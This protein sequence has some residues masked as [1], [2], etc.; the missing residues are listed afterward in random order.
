MWK[1]EEHGTASVNK[2]RFAEAK[3]TGAGT[4]A[5]GCPFCMVMLTGAAKA[6]GEQVKVLDMA[7][8][9]AARLKWICV[10]ASLLARQEVLPIGLHD[11]LIAADLHRNRPDDIPTDLG[12]YTNSP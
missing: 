9:L 2:T 12:C 11:I 4:L 10:F 8:I 6:D 7:K 1:E 3:A 5:V